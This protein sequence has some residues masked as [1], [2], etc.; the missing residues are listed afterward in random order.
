VIV[1][2]LEP[3]RLFANDL[4]VIQVFTN[5]RFSEPQTLNDRTVVV[6][7][8]GDEQFRGEIE[9]HFIYTIDKII[10]NADDRELETVKVTRTINQNGVTSM[11]TSAALT[12]S[13]AQ[14]PVGRY[15]LAATIKANSGG[16]AS[17]ANNAMVGASFEVYTGEWPSSSISGTAGDDVILLG[18]ASPSRTVVSVNGQTHNSPDVSVFIDSGAGDD[19]IVAISNVIGGFLATGSG[20]NDT[21]I[22]S[23]SNDSISGG[24][25]RDKIFGAGGDDDILG[26]AQG[27]WLFG[28]S[29]PLQ[30]TTGNDTIRGAGGNDRITDYFDSNYLLGGA[31]DDVF[32]CRSDASVITYTDSVSGGKGYDRAQVD[33]EDGLASIEERLT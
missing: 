5:D 28:D 11:I 26:G 21:I 25:G 22:G 9:V 18:T 13:A 2:R 7:N 14:L 16:D 15:F 23:D 3:R 19:K 31:G 17:S 1:E 4:E 30:F 27:D 20:G 6:Q 29:L 33:D 32:I 8:N 10:G 24:N 12:P